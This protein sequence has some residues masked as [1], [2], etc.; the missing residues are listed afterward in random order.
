[1]I[2][3]IHAFQ[4]EVNAY[5]R[6]RTKSV[7]NSH[8]DHVDTIEHETHQNI[9]LMMPQGMLKAGCIG[10]GLC[11][12]IAILLLQL[13]SR[14]GQKEVRIRRGDTNRRSP[15]FSATEQVKHRS[16]RTDR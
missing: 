15:A 1:M 8:G 5:L 6:H 2:S 10:K 4:T 9:N 14:Y 12:D 3:E 11:N 13:E 7:T 16:V